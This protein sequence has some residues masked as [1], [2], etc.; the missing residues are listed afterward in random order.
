VLV[1]LYR[2]HR[3]LSPC[4][5]AALFFGALMRFVIRSLKQPFPFPALGPRGSEL[6]GYVPPG[7]KWKQMNYGQGEGQLEIGGC[8]WGFYQKSKHELVVALHVGEFAASAA[9]DLVN[10]IGNMLHGSEP[11]EIVIQGTADE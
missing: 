10:N 1:S 5:S 8:E 9:F 11:F 6:I 4:R 2:R 3:R 7:V